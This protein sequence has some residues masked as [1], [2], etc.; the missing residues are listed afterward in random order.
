MP[1]PPQPPGVAWP[2]AAWPEGELPAEV[3]DDAVSAA[4][5]TLFTSVGRGGVPDTRAVLVVRGGEI[6][7]ERYAEDFGPETRFHSWSMGKSVVQ[8]LVGILV[9]EGR[10]EVDAPA[11]VPAWDGPDDPR[12]RLTLRHLLHMTTGLDN[13]DGG[14]DPAAFVGRLLFGPLARDMAGAAADVPL[15]H[16]PGTHWA[17][18][19]GTSAILGGIVSRLTGPDRGS[20]RRWMER[21][22]LEPL[23]IRSLVAEFD[24]HQQLVGGSHVWATARDWARLGLLYLRDGV[25]DGRPILPGGWVDFTRARAPAE[26]NGTYGAHFWLNR[27][28]REDQFQPLPGAPESAFQ[29]SGNGGQYVALVPDRDLVVVRLGEMSGTDWSTLGRQMGALVA[30]FP[31]VMP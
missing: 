5:D 14:A 17:Y 21:E 7:A 28:P 4:L 24:E 30:A 22:L 29:M 13:A 20:T 27:K 19:T 2:A 25:W 12:A 23:G 15:L 1:L 3:D 26:N 6:V 16:D 18:S 9:R 10:L 11:P 8:C 31:A